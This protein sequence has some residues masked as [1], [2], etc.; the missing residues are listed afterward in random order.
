M[1]IQ[2]HYFSG[3]RSSSNV[4]NSSA[5]VMI[6]DADDVENANAIPSILSN[7]SITVPNARILFV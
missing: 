1:Y 6:D 2:Y 4:Q 7:R 5:T 3:Q